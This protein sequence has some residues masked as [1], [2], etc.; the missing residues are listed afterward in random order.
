MKFQSIMYGIS[1]SIAGQK[2]KEEDALA[3]YTQ[4][5]HLRMKGTICTSFSITFQVQNVLMASRCP[6]MVC[7]LVHSKKQQ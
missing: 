6:L 3:T 1:P 7:C 2:E 5:I 4:Q